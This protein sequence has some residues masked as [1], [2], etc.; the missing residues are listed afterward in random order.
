MGLFFFY[1]IIGWGLADFS[2]NIAAAV[3]RHTEVV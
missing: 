1:V 2:V 3:M